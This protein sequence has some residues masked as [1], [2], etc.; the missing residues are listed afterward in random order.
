M[1]GFQILNGTTLEGGDFEFSDVPLFLE[2]LI[3]G[4]DCDC[5]RKIKDEI[6]VFAEDLISL[7]NGHFDAMEKLVAD[8]KV[9]RD[10]VEE[11][12]LPAMTPQS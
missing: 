11:Y 5:L 3:D 6:L 10:A 7:Q 1:T 12:S 9:I 4:Y 2:G 8:Y